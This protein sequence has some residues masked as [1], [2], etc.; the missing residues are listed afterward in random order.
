M[1][2]KGVYAKLAVFLEDSK[3][4]VWVKYASEKQ[5]WYS[6]DNGFEEIRNSIIQ[7][8][9]LSANVEDFDLEEVDFYGIYESLPE[10]AD[11]TLVID[12]DK[13]P[14]ALKIDE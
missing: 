8:L 10:D 11:P 12:Y 4:I 5:V 7:R 6:Y 13:H 3:H 9:P 1:A 2:A 14:N